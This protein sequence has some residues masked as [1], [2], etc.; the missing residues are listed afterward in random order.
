LYSER[1]SRLGR[2]DRITVGGTDMRRAK[3]RTTRKRLKCG[4]PRNV[5]RPELVNCVRVIVRSN[6][7]LRSALER[8]LGSYQVLV[9]G[10]PITD[11]EEILWQVDGTLQNAERATVIALG[12]LNAGLGGE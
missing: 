12:L 7:E 11:A 9:A 5:V 3:R 8:L 2:V 1:L 10:M 6:H 4:L